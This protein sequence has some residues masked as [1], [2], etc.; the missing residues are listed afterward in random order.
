[1]ICIKQKGTNFKVTSW[2]VFVLSHA[3]KKDFVE[4]GQR[5]LEKMGHGRDAHRKKGGISVATLVLIS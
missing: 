5:R 3:G 2:L 4:V 1:M